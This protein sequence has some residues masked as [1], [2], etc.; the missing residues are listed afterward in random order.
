M[1]A[2]DIDLLRRLWHDNVHVSEIAA[3]LGCGCELVYQLRLRHGLP[4]RTKVR[5]SKNADPTPEEIEQ[6][7]AEVWEMRRRGTPIGGRHD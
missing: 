4:A 2:Y 1:T 7:L 5:V 6:R 3:R